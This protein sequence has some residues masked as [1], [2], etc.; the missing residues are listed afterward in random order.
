MRNS[1]GLSLLCLT[2]FGC[3]GTPEPKIVAADVIVVRVPPLPDPNFTPLQNH[4]LFQR[5][6]F[7]SAYVH[8]KPIEDYAGEEALPNDDSLIYLSL[9]VDGQIKLNNQLQDGDTGAL[10]RLDEA[11]TDRARVGVYEPGSDRIVKAVGIKV[12]LSGKYGDLMRLAK[13]AKSSGAEPI[14]LLLD[15]HLPQQVISVP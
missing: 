6:L 4:L 7:P 2:F 10:T 5:F 8:D 15:G 11:F 12:P 13:I 14:I 9:T 3:A 1:I